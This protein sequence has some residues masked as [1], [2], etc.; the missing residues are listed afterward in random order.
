M[1]VSLHDFIRTRGPQRRARGAAGFTLTELMI[2]MGLSGLVAAALLSIA[3]VH[4]RNEQQAQQGQQALENARGALEEL[5]QSARSTAA[6]TASSR[7]NDSPPGTPRPTA[8]L[9]AQQVFNGAPPMPARD[10]ACIQVLNNQGVNGSDILMLMPTEPGYLAGGG[11][12]AV[13][14]S[15]PTPPAMSTLTS[16]FDSNSTTLTV[17]SLGP[18]GQQWTIGDFAA[19]VPTGFAAPANTGL[20]WDFRIAYLVAVLNVAGTTL[21]VAN[22]T[23]AGNEPVW[24]GGLVYRVRPVTYLIR[25]YFNSAVGSKERTLLAIDKGPFADNGKG[26][27]SQNPAL[28]PAPDFFQVVAENIVDLQVALWYDCNNDGVMFEKG[29]AAYDDELLYNFPG[30][31]PLAPPASQFNFTPGPGCPQQT[32]PGAGRNPATAAQLPGA[33]PLNPTRIS[34]IRISVVSRTSQP[35]ETLGWGRPS[36]EDHAADPAFPPGAD[37]SDPSTIPY[38]YRYRVQRTM[39]YFRNGALSQ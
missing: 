38:R 8:P 4:S 27:F 39:V 23:A 1:Y 14:P 20:L 11:P 7:L 6:W 33:G 24:P 31:G 36:L 19:V 2:V 21:T 17:D 15:S 25:P 3:Q 9:P 13:P 16:K 12:P 34:G 30:E 26:P 37:F 18:A 29:N 22:S 5:A 28:D 35:L 10:L 32:D